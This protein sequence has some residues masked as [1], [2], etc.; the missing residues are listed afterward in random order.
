MQIPG[1]AFI[2]GSRA[3]TFITPTYSGVAGSVGFTATYDAI[4][5]AY[6]AEQLI[7][8]AGVAAIS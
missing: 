1:I 5:C 6:T 7:Q 8:F 2:L 4:A 3:L